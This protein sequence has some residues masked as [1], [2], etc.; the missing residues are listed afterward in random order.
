MDTLYDRSPLIVTS[1]L[2]EDCLWVEVLNLGGYD[3]LSK[4]LDHKAVVRA[5]DSAGR[6]W[7]RQPYQGKW[8]MEARS[9]GPGGPER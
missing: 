5:I 4:L 2:A 6:N 7:S 3:V 1:R 9:A 8:A